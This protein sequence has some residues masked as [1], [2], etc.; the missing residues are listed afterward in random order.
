MWR[1][2]RFQQQK[3]ADSFM[4]VMNAFVCGAPAAAAGQP[5]GAPPWSCGDRRTIAAASRKI[6]TIH[7]FIKDHNRLD[8][9]TARAH[10]CSSVAPRGCAKAVLAA[11]TVMTSST[12]VGIVCRSAQSTLVAY[13]SIESNVH[14]RLV[15]KRRVHPIGARGHQC[16]WKKDERARLF[17]SRTM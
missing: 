1:Y 15:H 6:A 2:R 3:L 12:I 14:C 17:F 9:A 7:S 10:P 5:G 11:T 4:P 13:V 16:A 8:S